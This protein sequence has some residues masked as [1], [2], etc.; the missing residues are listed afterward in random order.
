LLA[1]QA[2]CVACENL[3]VHRRLSCGLLRALAQ[4][5]LGLDGEHFADDAG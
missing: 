5:W 2:I 4:I 1:R 3:D